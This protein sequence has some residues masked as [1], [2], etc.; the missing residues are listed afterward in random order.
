MRWP[1]EGTGLE[2]WVVGLRGLHRRGL[3][4]A[5]RDG[6]EAVDDRQIEIGVL[7]AVLIDDHATLVHQIHVAA[8][9]P[10]DADRLPL[11]D[12]DVHSRGQRTP[13]RRVAHPR[14]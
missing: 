3:M 9:D 10:A 12:D 4:Q 8:V 5:A 11:R 14:R 7:R 1:P 6:G 2:P 13:K